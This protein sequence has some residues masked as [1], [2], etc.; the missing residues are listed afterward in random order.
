MTIGVDLSP[1]QGPHR[2]RGI[3]SVLINFINHIPPE[4]RKA[5][6]FVFFVL[7]SWAASADPFEVLDLHG[8][9]YE[10]RQVTPQTTPGRR[11]PGRLNLLLSAQ[12]ALRELYDLRRG[13]SGITKSDLADLD[14]FLQ[15]DP[16]KPLPLHRKGLKKVLFLHDLIP[17]VLEWDYLWSY[18]T[19]RLHGFSRKAALRVHARRILYAYKLKATLKRADILMA[20]SEHTKSDFIQFFSVNPQKIT[21]THL[22]VGQAAD[23]AP[24]AIPTTAYRQTSWGY[25]PLRIDY[26]W[27]L[28]FV[29]FAGGADKRRKLEDLVGAFNILRSQ[30]HELKLVLAGDSMQG[31]MSI[32]TE[33]IQYALRTSSYLDDIIFLG[34]TPPP[35]LRWIYENATAF[36]FPSRYEG[37]GLP[38][39]EAMSYGTPVISYEN[40]ATKE[41]AG[42]RPIYVKNAH[43]LTDAIKICLNMSPHKRQEVH[44]KNI[45]KTKQWP[46]ETTSRDMLRI[47]SKSA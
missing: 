14:A 25:L 29:V 35:T 45:A 1:L 26:D 42:N 17:Y 20:N 11:L 34:F 40:P 43:G 7:P 30:G 16:A 44:D 22:G 33:E 10:T 9:S 41:V 28:P 24:T 37:F 4:D 39:L 15:I 32:A 46:W 8:L 3:G 47:I 2:M 31:P 12:R 18:W 5:H 6:L 13:H 23:K 36:I 21:V 19:A 38:V 27:K